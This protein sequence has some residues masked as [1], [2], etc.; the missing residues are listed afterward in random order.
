MV[1]NIWN[2]MVSPNVLLAY[3]SICLTPGKKLDLLVG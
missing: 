3:L 1:V 2:D